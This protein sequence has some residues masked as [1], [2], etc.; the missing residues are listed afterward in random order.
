[1]MSVVA[2]V[3]L[4]RHYSR[5]LDE[6]V[7][8]CVEFRARMLVKKSNESDKQTDRT[9]ITLNSVGVC[10]MLLNQ[11]FYASSH[12]LCRGNAATM[13][14]GQWSGGLSVLSFSIYRLVF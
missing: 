7:V 12:R 11:V 6:G 9:Q 8:V 14:M 10:C 2:Y 5:K 3:S 1:M 13:G 4:C